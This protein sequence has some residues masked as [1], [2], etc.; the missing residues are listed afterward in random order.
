MTKL[1]VVTFDLDN[2]LWDVDAVIRAAERDMHAWLAQHAPDV[3]RLI[4]SDAWRSLRRQVLTARPEIGHDVTAIRLAV[5]FAAFER[6]G[7]RSRE[8]NRLAATAFDV[9]LETR[10]KVVYF[11]GALEMLDVLARRYRI[12]ALSNG[13]AD[14][15]R[16][17]LNDIFTFKFSAADVGASKPSPEMFRAALAHAGVEP[18]QMVHV[19]DD[20][21]D[22]VEGAGSLG[23][24][25]IWVNF[26]NREYPPE[27]LPPTITVS[28]LQE[29]P[30]R[31][32]ELGP[33]A[34]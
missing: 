14:V 13:N 22:D 34:R 27:R 8:A 32:L 10:H 7:Y 4:H 15:R 12:G 28:R 25:S 3:M 33:R 6:C 26:A 16:L 17:G 30:E 29:I 11:D 9:F 2:T 21:R 23:I 19:G 1:A 20:P 18:E 31:L 24:A 5:L